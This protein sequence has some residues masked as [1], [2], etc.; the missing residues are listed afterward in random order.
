VYSRIPNLRGLLS[1]E[2][3]ATSWSALCHFLDEHHKGQSNL[4]EYVRLHTVDWPSE[5]KRPLYRWWQEKRAGRDTGFECLIQH[6]KTYIWEKGTKAGELRK[7]P[8]IPG[9]QMVW[10]PPTPSSCQSIKDV[11][12]KYPNS[13][14][15]DGFWLGQSPITQEQYS[16]VMNQNPSF[17]SGKKRPVE[18]VSW[19]EAVN[20]CDVLTSLLD[21]EGATP[22][23]RL[24]W[25]EELLYACNTGVDSK[26]CERLDLSA[27]HRENASGTTHEVA[28]KLP[29]NWGCYDMLGNVSEWC[30]D[31]MSEEEAQEIARYKK[32]QQYR[33]FLGGSWLRPPRES[34]PDFVWGFDETANY[35]NSIGFRLLCP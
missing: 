23:F 21:A 32:G 18:R 22:V 7:V 24:P 30:L 5:I 35:L 9:M 2:R 12:Q 11:Q 10:C 20:F 29:N 33:I 19:L 25:R 6:W 4:L 8:E 34:S 14:L 28:Q 31:L 1:A 13:L 15:S 16:F 17:F 27:W 3:N 26:V